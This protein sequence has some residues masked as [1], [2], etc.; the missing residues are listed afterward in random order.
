MATQRL[1]IPGSDNGTWGT[2]LNGFLEVSHNADGTLMSSAITTAGAIT[3][4]NGLTGSSVTLAASDVGAA[5]L[6][7]AALTGIPTAPTASSGT[8]T[9]Q[10]ATTAFTTAAVGA[11]NGTYVAAFGPI[12]SVYDLSQAPYNVAAGVLSDQSAAINDA[13][14]ALGKGARMLLPKGVVYISGAIQM[15]VEDQELFGWG[16]DETI[17]TCLSGYTDSHML[18]NWA[19]T[20][21]QAGHVD[22]SCTITAAS[23]SVTDAS[24][25]SADNGKCVRGIG[26]PFGT[27]VGTVTNATSFLLSSSP[28]SQVNVNATMTGTVSLTIGEPDHLFAPYK[29]ANP[30]LYPKV[31]DLE[32]NL[33]GN[34]SGTIVCVGRVHPQERSYLGNIVYANVGATGAGTNYCRVDC[35]NSDGPIAGPFR[36]QSEIGYSDGWASM[37]L[38]DATNNGKL[39][40]TAEGGGDVTIADLCTPISLAPVSGVWPSFSDSPIKLISMSGVTL[41]M[42]SQAQPPNVPPAT[43]SPGS[44]LGTN[45]LNGASTVVALSAETITASQP[46]FTPHMVGAVVTDSTT[47][48]NVSSNTYITAVASTGLTATV[49]Q[50]MTTASADTIVINDSAWLRTMDCVN[51]KLKDSDLSGLTGANSMTRPFTRNTTSGLNFAYPTTPMLIENVTTLPRYGAAGISLIEDYVSGPGTTPLALRIEASGTTT[52]SCVPGSIISYDG[53]EFVYYNAPGI[54]GPSGYVIQQIVRQFIQPSN[55]VDILEWITQGQVVLGGVGNSGAV[56]SLSGATSARPTPLSTEYGA[57]YFDTTLGLPVWW[58]GTTWVA[59]PGGAATVD[60]W[61]AAKPSAAQFETMPRM[62]TTTTYAMTSGAISMMAIW[63]PVGTTLTKLATAMTTGITF[64]SSGGSWW[65]CLLDNN[66]NALAFTADQ[67]T[68]AFG[69]ALKSLSIATTW[70]GTDYATESSWTTTYSGIHYFG[71]MSYPGTGGSPVAG[72]LAGAT[73]QAVV[74]ELS[75]VV[76]GR[77]TSGNGTS[78][79][80]LPAAVTGLT[81]PQFTVAAIAAGQGASYYGYVG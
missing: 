34:N 13:I 81:S 1:P 12:A 11:L 30:T 17:L 78:M 56:R 49:N 48:G 18:R 23:D 72:S 25:V 8:N 42:H 26:I 16:S 37:L 20:D 79:T 5:P 52:G 67:G 43:P 47:S 69:V 14:G 59:A 73:A 29:T 53:N 65:F 31:H 76:V 44:V 55:D 75:P 21:W 19:S 36:N 58:N 54:G 2:I 51:P 63:L 57:Q 32:F 7:S 71:V 62:L 10:L 60:N 40:N 28:T 22:V 27:F 3:S 24:I 38:L 61:L 4:V 66:Q 15:V 41:D 77:P 6:V 46:F 64:G 74:T 35:R 50:A 70:N 33:N 9:T 68:A 45:S 39:A 80:A